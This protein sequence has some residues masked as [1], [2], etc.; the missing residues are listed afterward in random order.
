MLVL[1]VILDANTPVDKTGKLVPP[2]KQHNTS[3]GFICPAETPE[4][5]SIGIVKNLT[6]LAHITI[7]QSRHSL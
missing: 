1:S 3:F 7:L 4:G 2:R 6:Y 5:A